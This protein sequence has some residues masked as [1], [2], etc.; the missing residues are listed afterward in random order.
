LFA[1]TF[2]LSMDYMVIMLSRIREFY[3]AGAS[4]SEAVIAGV[5]RIAMMVN[6]AAAIMV[7]VFASFA[8]AEISIV[9]ELGVGLAVAI[10]LDAVVIRLLVMPAAL[11]VLGPRVWGRRARQDEPVTPVLEDAPV[12]PDAEQLEEGVLAHA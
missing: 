10:A 9:R 6:G 11:L 7:A 12:A 2:G 8:T 1:V 4:H 3:R 5:G